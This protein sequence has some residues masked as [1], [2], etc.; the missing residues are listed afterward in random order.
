MIYLAAP[1]SH[2]DPAIVKGRMES[3]YAC[4]AHYMKM[5]EHIITPLFMHEVVVRN[6]DM[7]DD[8][9]YWGE[10]C[11]DLLKR[12]D[13]MIVLQLP[14]WDISRGVAQEIEFCFR[15]DIPVL[16]IMEEEWKQST[17]TRFM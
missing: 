9:H 7:D 14:G 5:G 12:C 4:L 15:R 6:E 2:P 13:R 10:Y 17:T 3:I 11:L 8:F 16:Y 1:Y